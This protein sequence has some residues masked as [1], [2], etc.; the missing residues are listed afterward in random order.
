MPPPHWSCG[1]I[2]GECVMKRPTDRRTVLLTAGTAAVAIAAGPVA[3]QSADISGRV[4]FEG[5]VVIPEGY[6]EIYLEDPAIRDHARRRATKTRI[7]SDGRSKSI[8]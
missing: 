2:N 1:A 6:L 8:A 5:S 3:A 4:T 7:K